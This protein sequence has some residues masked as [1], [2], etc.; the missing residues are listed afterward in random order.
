MQSRPRRKVIRQKKKRVKA[1]L[2]EGGRGK[3][4]GY[5]QS[6]GGERPVEPHKMRS[7]SLFVGEN[8]TAKF[9]MYP[10]EDLKE[11]KEKLSGRFYKK[12]RGALLSRGGRTLLEAGEG[13]VKN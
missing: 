8:E 1:L 11:G 7:E 5:S 10:G 9:C 3:K 13:E 12:K 6:G 2:S 4:G